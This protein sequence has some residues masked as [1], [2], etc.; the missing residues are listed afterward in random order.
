MTQEQE[1]LTLRLKV[2]SLEKKDRFAN[3]ILK[4]FVN[5]LVTLGISIFAF[6]SS[7]VDNAVLKAIAL[8]LAILF[9]QL[10]IVRILEIF[11]TR[12]N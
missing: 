5:I 3:S 1:L 11:K 2:K 10:V 12:F 8:T 9:F 7:K 4:K 6:V